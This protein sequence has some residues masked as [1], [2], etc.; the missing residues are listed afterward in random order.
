MSCGDSEC[1]K[2]EALVSVHTILRAPCGNFGDFSDVV[3]VRRE[4]QAF[5]EVIQS[6]GFREVEL[7]SSDLLYSIL[8]HPSGFANHCSCSTSS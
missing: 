1:A 6:A 5:G 7:L 2:R 3:C 4:K 8:I